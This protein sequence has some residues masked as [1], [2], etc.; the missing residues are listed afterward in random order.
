MCANDQGKFWEYHDVLF[1]SQ[2][3]LM[4]DDLK[5]HAQSIGLDAAK[6]DQC[7]SSGKYA[8]VVK[9]DMAAGSKAGVTGTP[10][11]FINGMMLSGAQPL[12]EF[13]R[14]IDAELSASK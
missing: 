2:D 6:F 7:L 1:K 3:K 9:K 12:D 5:Q 14:L 10:A 8:E 4:P 11:F 13:K